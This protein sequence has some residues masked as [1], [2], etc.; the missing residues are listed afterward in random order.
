ME[1]SLVTFRSSGER[2]EL[3]IQHNATIGRKKHCQVRV[4]LAEVSREHCQIQLREDGAYVVDLGSTNGTFVNHE[5]VQ[6]AKLKPGDH[7]GLGSV[8][9][10]AVI[11]GEP[12][13]VQPP[14]AAGAEPSEPEPQSEQAAQPSPPQE[15]PKEQEQQPSQPTTGPIE[16]DDEAASILLEGDEDEDDDFPF[17]D[18]EDQSEERDPLADLQAFAESL[19]DNKDQ[20][21]QPEHK[22]EQSVPLVDEEQEQK[23]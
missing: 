8:D 4:P 10:T 13:E 12:A 14:S 5:R 19:E 21:S 23:S 22:Q 1:L 15:K 18:E 2:R 11:N 20:P 6:E 3:P 9:F 7:I 17:S 16:D